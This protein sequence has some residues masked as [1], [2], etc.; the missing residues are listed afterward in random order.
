MDNLTLNVAEILSLLGLAQAIYVLVYMFFRAGEIKRAAIPFLYFTVF[1]FAFFADVAERFISEAFT[2]YDIYQWGLWMLGPPISVLVVIQVAQ[3]T[4]LPRLFNFWVLLL[5]PAAYFSAYQIADHYA[6]CD[7]VLSCEAFLPWLEITGL[8]AGALSLLTIWFRR[9]V[10]DQVYTGKASKDRYWLILTIIIMN[11][12]F[13]CFLLLQSV[14]TISS[15]QAEL[16]RTIVG[17]GLVYLVS[18]SVFRIYPQSLEIVDRRTKAAFL[19]DAEKD[20]A[21]KIESLLTL[22]KV[23]HDPGYSRSDLAKELG[24]SEAVI[25][26]VINRHY[27]RSFPQILNEYRVNDAKLLLEQTEESIKIVGNEVGF[28]STATFNRV[29]KDISGETPSAYRLKSQNK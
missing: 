1:S 18:T 20:T 4:R 21:N 5:V 12:F 3:I 15:V 9:D 8:F 16:I 27:K 17:A 7:V 23:Y 11:I 10:L 25:S 29:F 14:G 28:N 19:S 26:R 22:E 2:Y 13:L 24:L 6:G